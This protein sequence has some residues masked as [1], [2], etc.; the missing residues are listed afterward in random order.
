[1][2]F[3]TPLT[4]KEFPLSQGSARK[5]I[6]NLA[7]NHTGRILL[8][9]HAKQRMLERRVTLRQ[10]LNVLGHVRSRFTELPHQTPAG[11]WKC[12]LQGMAAG[13]LIEVVVVLKRFETDP[14][15]FV[16]TVMVN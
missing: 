1:M 6:N 7:S 8:S 5:I 9:A 16:I 12:N 3:K 4:V 2:D 15:A 13:E 10:I 14:S 11:D